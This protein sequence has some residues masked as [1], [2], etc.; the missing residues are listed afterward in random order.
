MSRF[1][2]GALL[3]STVGFAASCTCDGRTTEDPPPDDELL[4]HRIAPCEA[5]CE[6]QLGECGPLPNAEITTQAQCVR[7]CAS[8]DGNLSSGW[9]YQQS[10]KA[11]GCIAQWQA[12]AECLLALTCDQQQIYW[13]PVE[14]QPPFDERACSVEWRAMTQCVHEHPCCEEK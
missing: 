7:E 2:T 3:A 10:T 1:A 13:R 14:E 4:E 12:H 11:D 8:A 9:G 6:V 5:M